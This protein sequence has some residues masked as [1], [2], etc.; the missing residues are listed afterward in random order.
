MYGAF[1]GYLWCAVRFF[2]PTGS[3]RQRLS[4]LGALNA[5]THELITVTT[6]GTVDAETVCTLLRQIAA[7]SPGPT[8][9]VLDNARYQH[10]QMVTKLARSLNIHLLFLPSYSPNLNLIERLWKFI[11]SRALYSRGHADFAA[12]QSSVESC[13]AQ[14]KQGVYMTE[15]DS[16][17]TINFQTFEDMP[18][19]TA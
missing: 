16:L 1:L 13:I 3:G 19:V 5:I 12:M 4:V 11:K 15:L 6:C 10:C 8:T 18:T 14:I 9:L 17:L 2:V 7:A